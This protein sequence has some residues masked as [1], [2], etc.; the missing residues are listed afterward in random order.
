M[1]KKAFTLIELLVVIA[2]IGILA[3]MVM[4]GLQGA[5]AKARDAQRKSDVR[6]IKGA[7]ETSY[8]DRVTDAGGATVK[9]KERY[10]VQATAADVATALSWLTPDY[11]KALPTDPQGTNAYMYLGDASNYA[12]FAQ[13]ENDK[14]G[15]AKQTNPTI[16]AGPNG[17]NYWV[18]ND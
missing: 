1:K 8:S 18:Q 7:I 2:V 11:I 14:D 4:V 16:G 5:R 10:F 13:L 17:Y 9:D 12:V 15:D 6:S 3:A